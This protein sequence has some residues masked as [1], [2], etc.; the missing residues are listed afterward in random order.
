VASE[1]VSAE[2]RSAGVFYTPRHVAREMA[3][4]LPL[5]QPATIVDPACGEGSLLLAVAEESRVSDLEFV[6]IERNRKALER[7]RAALQAVG[8]NPTLFHADF[9]SFDLTRLSSNGVPVLVIMNPPFKGYGRLSLARRRDIR[10]LVPSLRGRFNLAH[11]F[12]KKAISGF[13]PTSVVALLPGNWF[14]ASYNDLR[15]PQKLRALTWKTLPETTFEG[16]ATTSGILKL[17]GFPPQKAPLIKRPNRAS[18]GRRKFRQGVASGA[19]NTFISIGKSRPK[20]GKVIPAARGRDIA[21]A[22]AVS[23]LPRIWL[24]PTRQ[25]RALD[26][27]AR[28]LE[29]EIQRALSARYCVRRMQKPWW[30]Y[31]ELP[32]RWFL[33]TPKLIVPEI[34]TRLSVF[35]DAQG[36]VLPL[37]STIA[38]EVSSL[39][40]ATRVGRFLK[41]GETW[42]RMWRRCTHMMNGAVRLTVPILRDLMKGVD[43]N[44]GRE[45][46]NPFRNE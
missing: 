13:Q 35:H 10:L 20:L 25:T 43:Y 6:G 2:D 14:R 9:L 34:C 27:F 3:R 42:Q 45:V 4:L 11:A 36:Q 18:R 26:R 1:V 32:P 38:I 41:T 22:V 21:G 24:P 23:N 5:D 31:H 39:H 17:S 29:E 7:C 30:A 19:D 44:A 8:L 40:D 12:L 46:R 28:E 33:G 37:H 16:T 15:G